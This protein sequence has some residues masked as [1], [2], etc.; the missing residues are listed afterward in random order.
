MIITCPKLSYYSALNEETKSSVRAKIKSTVRDYSKD[1][2][3][4]FLEDTFAKALFGDMCNVISVTDERDYSQMMAFHYY[5]SE[6]YMPEFYNV[7]PH[8]VC[9]FVKYENPSLALASK[10]REQYTNKRIAAYEKRL[11]DTVL[12]MAGKEKVI[13]QF[14]GNTA[15]RGKM[16]IEHKEDD[17]ILNICYNLNNDVINHYYSGTWV[18]SDIAKQILGG[19]YG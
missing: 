2:P 11:T 14:L 12:F 16:Q 4:V 18:N 5:E 1:K 7:Y 10:N 6:S 15:S 13:L 9:R 17:G 3:T 19:L 8:E